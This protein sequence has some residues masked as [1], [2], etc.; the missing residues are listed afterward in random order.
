MS[1]HEIAKKHNQCFLIVRYIVKLKCA[2]VVLKNFCQ[3]IFFIRALKIIAS[4]NFVN[5]NILQSVKLEYRA[6]WEFIFLTLLLRSVRGITAFV[7]SFL[8]TNCAYKK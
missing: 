6:V 4:I 5:L 1:R 3:Y 7:L 8:E 2:K